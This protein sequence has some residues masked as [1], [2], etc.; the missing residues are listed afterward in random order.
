ML[1][2]IEK[3]IEA[4]GGYD[5]VD[6]STK[7]MPVIR[8]AQLLDWACS[9]E[10]PKCLEHAVNQ[11]KSWKSTGHSTIP[12]DFRTL[13]L[14]AAV[15]KQD[16]DDSSSIFDFILEQYKAIG[17]DGNN[18]DG[19]VAKRKDQYLTA[20]ANTRDSGKIQKLLDMAFQ[21]GAMNSESD[22]VTLL[23]NLA[24]NVVAS[25]IILQYFVD[26]HVKIMESFGGSTSPI[27]I[28]ATAMAPHLKSL[29]GLF[30]VRLLC[31]NLIITCM[32]FTH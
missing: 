20:L 9:L 32:Q 6:L 8:H 7:G 28:T 2:R 31:H 1:P 11:V 17:I 26:N 14:S 16:D 24:S 18:D 13:L 25:D 4:T 15:S 5:A 29:S 3:A 23:Q 10:S 30:L 22:G 27:T 21:P 12:R 19:H